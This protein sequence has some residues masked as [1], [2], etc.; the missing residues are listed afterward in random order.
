MTEVNGRLNGWQGIQ[1]YDW[2]VSR[3]GRTPATLV[4]L[5]ESIAFQGAYGAGMNEIRDMIVALAVSRQS[6]RAAIDNLSAYVAGS[7]TKSIRARLE[8]NTYT[9]T[10]C[11][12]VTVDS[13]D[14][15]DLTIGDVPYLA[16]FFHL[17]VVGHG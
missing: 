16:A 17:H 9:W 2:G 4:T 10:S 5:P 6:D 14:F 7:G 11:D 12:V 1:G 15:P 3:L 8:D 13:V